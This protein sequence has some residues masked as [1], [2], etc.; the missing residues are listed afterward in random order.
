[1]KKSLHKN[2]L[3]IHDVFLLLLGMYISN[4]IYFTKRINGIEEISSGVY[5]GYFILLITNILFFIFNN[6]Y[7]YQVLLNKSRQ[8]V[9]ILKSFFSSF[10]IL[11]LFSF[12]FKISEVTMNRFL[13]GVT[14]IILLV[15]FIISRIVIIPQIYYLLVKSRRISRKLLVIGAGELGQKKAEHLIN[16]NRSYYQV[17]GFLDDDNNKHGTRIKGFEVLGGINDL[18]TVV[19]QNKVK[20]IL[21]AINNIDHSNLLK[22]IDE[23]KKTKCKVHVISE[24]YNII[25]KK[26]EVEEVAGMVTFSIVKS[27]K[28][29]YE[30]VKRIIDIIISLIFIIIGL[31]V[32]IIIGLLIKLSSPGP[33]FYKANVIG[34]DGQAFKMYKFRSMHNNCSKESHKKLIEKIIK[35]N[36]ETKK[37]RNDPRITKIG[38]FMRKYSID[39]FPQIINVLRGE[40]SFV[41]P[42]PNIPY[43]Y[44]IMDNWQ[45]KRQSVIPGI[46]G[47][48]Q[49]HGRDEVNYNDQIVLDIYYIEN[50]S[51][52]LD[53]EILLNTVSVVL[54]GKGG[55]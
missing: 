14:F 48:W 37:I 28:L 2:L 26:L 24:L 43:E 10:I 11:I 34:K 53:F 8:I 16:D 7:K 3:V 38:K 4:W 9:G 17:C 22:L 19:D 50:R 39:E 52:K 32:W 36:R 42:R 20:E 12:I 46:T 5:W 44:E 1:M 35:E 18:Q 41:G 55:I 45:K 15:F 27:N 25:E 54:F 29:D 40:M 47:L 6:L 33:I 21:I 23:C 51:I 31:P 30:K 13:F 49:V